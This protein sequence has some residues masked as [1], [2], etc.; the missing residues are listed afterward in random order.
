[1][2]CLPGETT[3]LFDFHSRLYIA[4]FWREVGKSTGSSWIEEGTA[5]LY[6]GQ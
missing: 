1:M 6:G 4:K 3:L 5:S 2:F